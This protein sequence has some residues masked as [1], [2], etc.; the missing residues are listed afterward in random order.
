MTRPA[1]GQ[2]SEMDLSQA[3]ILFTALIGA[4]LVS[5]ACGTPAPTPSRAQPGIAFVHAALAPS[6]DLPIDSGLI[7]HRAGPPC[8]RRLR[9]LPLHVPG[10]LYPPASVP[11]LGDVET[12]CDTLNEILWKYILLLE[13]EDHRI[14]I[15]LQ[16]DWK[17]IFRVPWLLDSGAGAPKEDSL[18]VITQ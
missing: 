10:S 5:A 7:P 11:S 1:L 18:T 6:H 16:H 3:E 12:A 13:A 9:P 15:V 17:G 4:I 14:G 2:P 8:P